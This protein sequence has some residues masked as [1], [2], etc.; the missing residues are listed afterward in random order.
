MLGDM[1]AS[2][3][4]GPPPG[5]APSSDS[6]VPNSSRQPP[7]IR[8]V[9]QA[10]RN[11]ERR[12]FAEKVLPTPAIFHPPLKQSFQDHAPSVRTAVSPLSTPPLRILFNSK[13][14]G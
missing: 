12:C 13:A 11:R 3:P 4:C 1:G 5:P 14:G 9:R 2:V 7:Q 8:S 6:A 10:P